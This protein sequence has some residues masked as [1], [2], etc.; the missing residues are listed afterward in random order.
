MSILLEIGAGRLSLLVVRGLGGEDRQEGL[1]PTGIEFRATLLGPLL[2]GLA[3]G[4]QTLRERMESLFGVKTIDN[5]HRLREEL[6]GE[7]PDPPRSVS[8]DDLPWRL[9]KTASLAFALAN[10]ESWGSVSRVAALSMA[11]V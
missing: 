11:A 7:I 9:P 2:P 5:L 4:I 8:Q 10:S 1:D 3:V 6:A